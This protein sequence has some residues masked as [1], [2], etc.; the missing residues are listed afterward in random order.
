MI[1]NVLMTMGILSR[2]VPAVALTTAIPTL[3][4]RGA[5]MSINSLLQQI[6]GCL[7]AAT[8]GMIVKQKTDF[9]PLEHYNTVGSVMMCIAY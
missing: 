7:A 5:L 2:I 6:V 3:A 1:A 4:N 9:S 8:A